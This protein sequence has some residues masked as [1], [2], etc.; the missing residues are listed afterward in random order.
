MAFRSALPN[1]APTGLMSADQ[2]L[3]KMEAQ[4]EKEAGREEDKK[5][6]EPSSGPAQVRLGEV[7]ATGG[8]A[9]EEVQRILQKEL[10]SFQL[11]FQ[12]ALRA[13]P[14]LKGKMILKL[15]I[16][17]RGRVTE[18]KVSETDLKV[19]DSALQECIRKR[20]L[21]LQFPAPAGGLQV[22]VT[23]PFLLA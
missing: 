5:N 22:T 12:N 1:L 9:K 11:C 6:G 4:K 18:V 23:V 15:T 16:D 10:S 2:S 14:N 17:A 3:A 21:S 13:Q 20:L 19:K 7:V 8:L